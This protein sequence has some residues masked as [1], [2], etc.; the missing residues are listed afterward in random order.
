MRVYLISKRIDVNATGEYSTSTNEL[1]V[2]TGSL[3]SAGIAYSKTFHGGNSIE[4]KR[5]DT[6]VNRRTIKDVHFTSP[7]T[8]ANFVTG[9]STNGFR[10]WKDAKGNPLSSY[11]NHNK[12]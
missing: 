3:V 6:V 12:G 9:S 1:T 11:K 7:S 2:L 4:K 5:E 10:V 8:A